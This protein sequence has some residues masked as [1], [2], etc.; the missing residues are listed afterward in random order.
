MLQVIDETGEDP[1]MGSERF[2]TDNMIKLV[3]ITIIFFT[4]LLGN[5]TLTFVVNM[6]AKKTLRQKML[7]SVLAITCIIRASVDF[8][9]DIYVVTFHNNWQFNLVICKADAFLDKFSTAVFPYVLI[10]LVYDSARFIFCHNN[11]FGGKSVAS[12]TQKST[13]SNLVILVITFLSVITFPLVFS[14]VLTIMTTTKSIGSYGEGI[15]VANSTTCLLDINMFHDFSPFKTYL[16]FHAPIWLIFIPSAIIAVMYTALV[17][18]AVLIKKCI[19]IRSADAD[20]SSSETHH[21]VVL[22]ERR[23]VDKNWL[24][25][26]VCLCVVYVLC[27]V[28]YVL[29]KLL[30]NYLDLPNSKAAIMIIF[31]LFYAPPALIPLLFATVDTVTRRGYLQH[32]FC[33]RANKRKSVQNNGNQNHR[34]LKTETSH[35][36][37]SGI[38][39]STIYT[40]KSDGPG[41]TTP[42]SRTTCTTISVC[43]D[44]D[45][46]SNAEDEERTHIIPASS[47][48]SPEDNLSECSSLG[49]CC[50]GRNGKCRANS[51]ENDATPILVT[52]L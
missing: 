9:R 20:A 34:D 17:I 12:Y 29:T 15:K 49:E 50:D 26:I 33:I 36:S 13:L 4:A 46:Y 37:N 25:T 22:A 30:Y 5:G 2:N 51:E 11:R 16:L 7:I 28:P 1:D 21:Q 18:K 48:Q 19:C 39:G 3:L 38:S 8:I 45:R 6:V 44:Y 47:S 52:S 43:S 31:F 24:V 35:G 10:F 40:N 41:A 23:R 42:I 14:I 32:L 27:Y